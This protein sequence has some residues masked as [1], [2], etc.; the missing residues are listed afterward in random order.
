MKGSGNILFKEKTDCEY[1]GKFKNKLKCDIPILVITYHGVY[2]EDRILKSP[3]KV[4]K[5]NA[6]K[7]GTCNLL[8]PK[9]SNAIPFF[10]NWE[11]RNN[12]DK[13]IKNLRD[14][15]KNLDF[16]GS[17]TGKYN[18][19]RKTREDKGESLVVQLAKDLVEEG[20]LDGKTFIEAIPESY[21]LTCWDKK[22]KYL[23]KFYSIGIEDFPSDKKNLLDN[24]MILYQV[25][26]QPKDI[27]PSW[28]NNNSFTPAE[29]V[30]L[31]RRKE[32]YFTLEEILLKLKK[33][34]K[35]DEVL[36]IDLACNLIEDTEEVDYLGYP[37]KAI[38][39]RKV[40][41]YIRDSAPRGGRKKTKKTKKTK[42]KRTKNNRK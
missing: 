2:D 41:K 1:D 35:L 36:I 42:K 16:K 4:Y 13:M 9:L 38:T 8:T 33:E 39:D 20:D 40:R 17:K 3:L 19:T 25:N 6:S 12:C 32:F 18:F 21:K 27:V 23:N 15:L 37:I 11:R 26:K 22:E 29:T 34:E 28:I 30:M 10:I 24:R 5:I 14:S 7:L 31:K